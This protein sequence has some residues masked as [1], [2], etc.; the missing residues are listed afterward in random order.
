MW[1][2]SKSRNGLYYNYYKIVFAFCFLLSAPYK[3]VFVHL[4]EEIKREKCIEAQT[5]WTIFG[6]KANKQIIKYEIIIIRMLKQL[7]CV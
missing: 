2:V 3:I 1:T 6:N 7:I 5:W 4:V